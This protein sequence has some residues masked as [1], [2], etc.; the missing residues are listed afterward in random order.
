VEII[1]SDVN[2]CALSENLVWGTLLAARE[3]LC[4]VLELQVQYSTS[5]PPPFL[6]FQSPLA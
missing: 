2:Y 1:C 4:A 6:L 5:S 3:E